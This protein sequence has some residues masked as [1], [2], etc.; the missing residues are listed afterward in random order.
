MLWIEQYS[1][2][3]QKLQLSSEIKK[4]ERK[5]MYHFPFTMAFPSTPWTE[6]FTDSYHSLSFSH[7]CLDMI[8]KTGPFHLRSRCE[9]ICSLIAFKTGSADNQ[10]RREMRRA[11]CSPVPFSQCRAKCCCTLLPVPRCQLCQSHWPPSAGNSIASPTAALACEWVRSVTRLNAIQ[12]S[13]VEL[14]LEFVSYCILCSQLL[15]KKILYL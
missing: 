8:Q 3:E 5:W 2:V 4:E 12:G 11:F 9:E 15:C 10:K 7:L 6:M 13:V 1:C 14:C